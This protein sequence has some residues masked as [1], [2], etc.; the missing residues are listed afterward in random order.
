MTGNYSIFNHLF[1][2][3][4]VFLKSKL[5]WTVWGDNARIESSY[6][7]GSGRVILVHKDV[8][9]P[10]DL[11]LDV[12]NSRLYWADIKKASIQVIDVHGK[13]QPITVWKFKHGM[14]SHMIGFNIR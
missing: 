5:F 11:A 3:L 14:S 7:D 2:C 1:V 9:W 10:S 6:L 4:F 8:L 12:A 13:Q